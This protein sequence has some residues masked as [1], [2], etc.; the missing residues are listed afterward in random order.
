M[1][2]PS[3]ETS[4]P[5][6][7]N[8]PCRRLTQAR[9]VPSC[10]HHLHPQTSSTQGLHLNRPVA[11]A[12]SP[13][14]P[15][16]TSSYCSCLVDCATSSGIS[17]HPHSH[18][19]KLGLSIPGPDHCSGSGQGWGLWPIQGLRECGLPEAQLR[20]WFSLPGKQSQLLITSR[21]ETEPPTLHP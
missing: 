8:C 9:R 7:A 3:P 18:R 14:P 4:E 21:E 1:C 19:P 10:H 16:A 11:Q 5:Y 2:F 17:L 13:P 6:R 12:V 15:P 20:V